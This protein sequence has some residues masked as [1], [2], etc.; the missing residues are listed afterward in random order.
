MEEL[1]FTDFSPDAT[2]WYKFTAP[3]TGEVKIN[4]FSDPDSRG[5]L[6][7]TQIAVFETSDNTCTGTMVGITADGILIT[8]ME[9]MN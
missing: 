2:V 3:S 9:I 1:F 8:L 4:T 6:L 5:D 7:Y